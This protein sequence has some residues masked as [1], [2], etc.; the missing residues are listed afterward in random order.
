MCTAIFTYINQ[1]EELTW[2]TAS[3][4]ATGGFRITVPARDVA[5][6]FATGISCRPAG[7]TLAGA[8]DATDQKG[9]DMGTGTAFAW[10]G[11]GGNFVTQ[12]VPQ[13]PGTEGGRLSK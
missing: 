4:G 7:C 11:Q 2:A 6:D 12:A 10:R 5:S 3:R 8:K 1:G 9:D 13:P